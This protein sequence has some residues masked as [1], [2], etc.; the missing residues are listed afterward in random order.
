ME[1]ELQ[2]C[3]SDGGVAPRGA[4]S[5]QWSNGEGGLPALSKTKVLL[6]V[7]ARHKVCAVAVNVLQS[8]RLDPAPL[9]LVFDFECHHAPI[10]LTQ[11][12]RPW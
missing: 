10:I 7:E 6:D 11:S 5:D 4:A 2:P 12:R 8:P 3:G 1:E 9:L